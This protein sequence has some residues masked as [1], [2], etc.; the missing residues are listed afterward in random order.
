V[1]KL[2]DLPK[3]MAKTLA[4]QIGGLGALLPPAPAAGAPVP[5]KGGAKPKAKPAP[6]KAAA[7]QLRESF[8]VCM[9]SLEHVLTP[10]ADLAQAVPA[11]DRWCHL[12]RSRG[13]IVQFAR[14]SE[15]K[16]FDGKSAPTITQ[17]GAVSNGAAIDAAIDCVEADARF[18]TDDSVVRWLEVPAFYVTALLVIKGEELYAVLVSQPASFTRLKPETVYAF[19]DFLAQL[20]QEPHT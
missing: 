19:K 2:D 4:P 7:M 1:A 9:V 12:I 3:G 6:A 15:A 18:K 10:P 16:G 11:I 5:K 14:S 8:A 13:K 17:M 20:A